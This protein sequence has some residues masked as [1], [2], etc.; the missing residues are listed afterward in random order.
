MSTIKVDKEKCAGCGT[1]WSMFPELFEAGD[2]GKSEVKSSDYEAHS[3]S[4]DE[5]IAVCPTGAISV[6][7]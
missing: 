1:C 6:E 2:D 5:V 3:Y 7:E 4:P